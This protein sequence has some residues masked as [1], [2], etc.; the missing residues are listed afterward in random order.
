M[1]EVSS[2][3]PLLIQWPGH[4][5]PGR[6]TS[7]LVQNIDYAP[8]LLDAAGVKPSTPMH[9]VSL[10]P[11][12]EAKPLKW[13]RD[14][15]YHFYE[16]PGFHGVARHY[17]VR[18]DRYK[19][20][21]YYQNDEWELFDL[22]DDPEDQKNLFGAAGYADITSDLKKR[23]ADLRIQYQ[24]PNTDPEAPWYHGMLIRVIEQLLKLK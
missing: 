21:H 18:T 17:G 10:L 6:S 1:D 15:Y 14:L 11:L 2:R 24:V 20:I 16:N 4:I 19:L 13:Q 8:T 3:V 9:G 12:F 5:A 7:A 23:L 22:E